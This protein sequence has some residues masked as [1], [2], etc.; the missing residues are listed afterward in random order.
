[1]Y[2]CYKFYNPVCML[3]YKIL[4]TRIHKNLLMVNK[5]E[6]FMSKLVSGSNFGVFVVICFYNLYT[7]CNLVITTDILHFDFYYIIYFGHC[8][9]HFGNCR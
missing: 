9:L 3:A 7:I 6:R 1:M 8:I 2:N 5:Q 4:S